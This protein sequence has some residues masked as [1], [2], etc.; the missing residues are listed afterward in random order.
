MNQFVYLKLVNGEQLMALKES[1]DSD[2]IT[3]KFPMLIKTHLVSVSNG[4]IAEQVT[5]GPYSLFGDIEQVH[6]NKRHVVLDTELAERAIPHYVGLVREHEGVVIKYT[7]KVLQWEDEV[8]ADAP[9]EVNIGKVLD[10][11]K[12]ITQEEPEEEHTVST[13]IEG[14]KTVH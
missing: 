13:F 6:I 5:A 8:P 3:I 9:E 1:E 2:T 7:P 10:A 12:A 11:L 4:K 14:N